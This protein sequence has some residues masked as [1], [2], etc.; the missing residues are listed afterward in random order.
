MP[1]QPIVI[2]EYE[3]THSEIIAMLLKGFATRQLACMIMPEG[4]M[5]LVPGMDRI[6]ADP[7]S[8][9]NFQQEMIKHTVQRFC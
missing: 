3:L 8:A 7:D 1:N 2:T 9:D 5:K 4:A 6:F